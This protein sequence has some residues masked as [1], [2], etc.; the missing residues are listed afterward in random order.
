M[1]LMF[2]GENRL[3]RPQALAEAARFAAYAG[4][5]DKLDER[6]DRL[7]LQQRKAVEFARAL[8]CRPRL[9]LVDEVASGL[10]PAEVRRFVETYPRGARHLRHHG[11]LGRAHHLRAHPG[12]RPAGRAGAGLD[13]R[14][15]PAAGGAARTSTCCAPISAA[16]LKERG[17]MLEVSHL[18]VDHGQLRALWD[19]SFRV[20][21]GERV[22]LLGANG[23]GK[24]TTLGAIIGLYRPAGGTISYRGNDDRRPRH[25][26]QCR[27]RHCAGAGRPPAV[28]GNDGAR[29][30]GDGRLCPRQAQRRRRARSSAATRCFRCSRRRPASRPASSPAASSR[31][32]RSAAR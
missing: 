26:R 8:A 14:R 2:R 16:T 27:G 28:P 21:Q 22:A 32:S 19:V 17:V 3:G 11:D 31:W 9:L 30:P 18:A 29:E 4:L 15:R 1:P 7:T 12:G 5:G 25:R 23:A 10:T 6:A 13:H 24:S 20:E